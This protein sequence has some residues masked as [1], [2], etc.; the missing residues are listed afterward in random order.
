MET[1]PGSSLHTDTSEPLSKSTR[2]PL[3]AIETGA[4]HRFGVRQFERLSKAGHGREVLGTG[5]H[6]VLLRPA[7]SPSTPSHSSTACPP[8]HPQHTGPLRAADLVRRERQK[9]DPEL[10][11]PDRDL[12]QSLRR[13]AQQESRASLA[14]TPASAEDGRRSDRL[15]HSRLVVRMLE[16]NQTSVRSQSSLEIL[17]RHDACAGSC[18]LLKVCLARNVESPARLEN[19]CVLHT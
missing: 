16:G 14:G 17:E 7:P 2:E 4:L 11:R 12:S 19:R 15:K 3:A 9:I 6:A 1:W 18:D 5:S 10:L 13:V 8:A